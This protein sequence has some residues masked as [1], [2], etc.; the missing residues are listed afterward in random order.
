MQY[1]SLLRIDDDGDDD[2]DDG[3]DGDGDDGRG[4]T[5]VLVELQMDR[6]VGRG[7]SVRLRC[8]HDVPPHLLDKVVFL[9]QGTKIFQ[10]IKNRKPPYRNFTTPGAVLN[11][12]LATENSII[13]QN[14]ELEASGRYS[15]EVSL[16]TPI[17]TKASAEKQLTVFLFGVTG[18]YPTE[19]QKHH[20]RIEVPPR[21]PPAAPFRARCTTAPSAPAPHVTWFINGKKMDELLANSQ[22]YRVSVSERSWGARRGPLTQTSPSPLLTLTHI[23]HLATRPPGCT[24]KE[25]ETGGT[26]REDA[27]TVQGVSRHKWR[28]RELFVTVSEVTVEVSGRLQLTCVSTIPEFRSIHDKF[29][30]IRNETVIV[31]VV[32]P[33]SQPEPASNLTTGHSTSDAS[34]ALAS[35]LITHIIFLHLLYII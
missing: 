20:P 30:D 18:Q 22:K 21:E 4:H 23:T 27:N 6:W 13:L 7:G 24:Q 16:E 31:E 1:F 17:Y 19:P 8:L 33:S 25:R 14:L 35:P 5:E 2:D 3:G 28:R 15:C 12:A 10:Y 26:I 34:S 29:A 11:I 9:R 32:N